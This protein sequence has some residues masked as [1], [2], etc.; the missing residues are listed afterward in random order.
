MQEVA[1]LLP[2]YNSF[3]PFCKTHSG[4]DSYKCDLKSAR[5]EYLPEAHLLLFH[6][7]ANRFLRGMVR[8]IVGACV[9]A[10]IGQITVED[11]KTALD[12]Q[13]MLKKSLSVPPQ[14]LFLTDV[15]YPYEL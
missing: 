3:F 4:V 8:L 11:V 12:Q 10:G 2:Q 7:T 1:D 13:K 15:K 9:Q 5:W 14:G 6:I